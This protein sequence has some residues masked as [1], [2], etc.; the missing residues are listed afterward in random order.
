EVRSIAE[1]KRPVQP[2]AEALVA[3]TGTTALAPEF[4]DDYLALAFVK[5]YGIG[6]RWTPGMDWMRNADTHW[7][8]DDHLTRYNVA[9][10]I[11]RDASNI[12][13]K[14]GTERKRLASAKTV[15]AVLAMAQSDPAIVVPSDA[16]DADPM[17]LNTPAGVVDLATGQM[18][19]RS[20]HDHFTQVT[21]TAPSTTMRAPNWL[22]FISEVF[23]Y[24]ADVIAF[25]QRVLGYC[26]TGDRREQKLF[27]FWG[28]GANG[29]STLID[30]VLWVLGTYALKL[31]TT[32]L[33]QSSIDRHPTELAQLRGRRLALSNELDEGQFWAEA[34]IKELTGDEY[35]TARFMRQDFFEFRQ[36]QKHLIAGNFK[37]R[38]RGGDPAMAR[39]MALIP[40]L[41]KFEGRHRDV[42][43]P[44]KLRV[45][46]P[47][48]L[49]WIIKGAVAWHAEGLG[50]PAKVAD[51][52]RDYLAEHDDV[53]MWIE[54][55]CSRELGI[56]DSASDL[57]QSFAMWKK[58]RGEHPPSQTTW[59][60]RMALVPGLE[61][62]RSNG[63]KYVGIRLTIDSRERLNH[64]RKT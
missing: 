50:I 21:S 31:P 52:S 61:K 23:S 58:D 37:P 1:G 25:V 46:A 40:F 34:R 48:V 42:T 29:K 19:S 51:A 24:D 4:S 9:R 47:A 7:T 27:F 15:A 54:E 63:W 32:A 16:W 28:D 41:E 62:K 3:G 44:A 60:Q 38:L 59:G 14:K 30:L 8:R 5:R 35:L 45:E 56:T 26:L 17:L 64:A 22:R 2:S 33:M 20:Q 13:P 43:L 57:Y 36:T 39:R 53:S 55:N 10:M 11:C 6:Y 18:R 12:A 49:A